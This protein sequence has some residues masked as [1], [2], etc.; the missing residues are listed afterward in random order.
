MVAIISGLYLVTSI[1]TDM[2]SNTASGF[3]RTHC[4]WVAANSGSDAMPFVMAVTFAVSASFSTPSR[5]PDQ[6][7]GLWC[8]QLSLQRFPACRHLA[9]SVLLVVTTLLI[10]PIYPV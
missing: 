1:L 3:D 2:S 9:E 10:L 7:H 6:Y 8:R 4:H 5:L